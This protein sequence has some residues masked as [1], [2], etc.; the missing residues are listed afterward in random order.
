MAGTFVRWQANILIAVDE[1]ALLRQACRG[2]EA[3]F[4][5]LFARYQAR[6]HQYAARMCG[7]AAA[8]DIVQ[9]TFL[10]ILRAAHFDASKGTVGAYLFGIARHHV[11]KQLAARAPVLE[12]WRRPPG[13]DVSAVEETPDQLLARQQTVAAVREAVESLPPLSR[14]VIILC[15]LQE[16]DYAGVAELIQCPIGTVRSRLHRARNLLAARLA[17]SEPNTATTPK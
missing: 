8:D 1:A 11:F 17:E 9:E 14:E 3:E 10:S 4:C 7:I 5:E 13:I 12:Q 6:L 2:G 16:M 15:D